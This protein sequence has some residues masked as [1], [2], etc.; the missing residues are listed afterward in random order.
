MRLRNKRR[1]KQEDNVQ[2]LLQKKSEP[3]A[4]ASQTSRIASV[5]HLDEHM[6]D[7]LDLDA[8]R[9]PVQSLFSNTRGRSRSHPT[10]TEECPKT[11]ME[12][13]EN[14]EGWLNCFML[15]GSSWS[16]ERT[17]LEERGAELDVIIGIEL[18]LRGEEADQEWNAYAKEGYKIAAADARSTKEVLDGPQKKNEG[19]IVQLRVNCKRRA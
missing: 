13:L 12:Y 4:I 11:R 8:D 18:K 2:E 19:L 17:L 10:V 14:K 5:K 1:Q 16:T 3:G 9:L 15:N 7:A 6:D